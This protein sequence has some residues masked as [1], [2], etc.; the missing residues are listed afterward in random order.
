MIEPTLFVFLPASHPSKAPTDEARVA[1]T[2][3][4]RAK[5]CDESSLNK[6]T[7]QG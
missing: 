6:T 5:F 1:A 4:A 2:V 7:S 3:K